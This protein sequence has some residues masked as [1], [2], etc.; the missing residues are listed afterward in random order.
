MHKIVL[1]CD[2]VLANFCLH[3]ANH[4]GKP[5]GKVNYWCVETMDN[6]YGEGWFAT[7]APIK[8]FWETIPVLSRPSD[9]DF[10][11]DSYMSSFPEEM[12]DIR[13]EWLRKNGFPDAP[14]I[15]THDKLGECIKR[16]ATHL[17]DDKPKTIA[18]LLDS[19][20]TGIHFITPYAGFQPVGTKVITNLKQ[21]KQ[22]L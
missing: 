1:V 7:I 6:I 11:V 12:Y 18:Q 20:V 15:V 21:V 16:G 14:L 9:I 19:P 4:F 13:V 22:Y 8:E 17:V 5:L 2:D 10:E 3:A